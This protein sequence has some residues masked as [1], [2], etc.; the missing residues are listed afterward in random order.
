MVAQQLAVVGLGSPGHQ[1][2]AVPPPRAPPADADRA[3]PVQLP[4]GERAALERPAEREHADS[5]MFR[6]A[7]GSGRA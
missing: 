3:D 2:S 4:A 5:N 1:S 7:W 6:A